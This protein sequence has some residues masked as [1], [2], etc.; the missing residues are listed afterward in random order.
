MF[1]IELHFG[2]YTLVKMYTPRLSIALWI[3][4]YCVQAPGV[5]EDGPMNEYQQQQEFA[6]RTERVWCD[7]ILSQGIEEHLPFLKHDTH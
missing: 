1:A 2:I 4:S 5:G 7:L 6:K 3:F